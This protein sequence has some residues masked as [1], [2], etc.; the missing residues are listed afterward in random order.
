MVSKIS[1]N[2][3]YTEAIQKLLAV[4]QMTLK[5]TPFI[6]QGDEMGLVNYP[7]ASVDEVT[8][9]EAKGLVQELREKGVSEE[10]ILK[11]IFAGTREHTRILLPWNTYPDDFREEMRQPINET[12]TQAYKE[13]IALRK[14]D[15]AL[16]YGDFK[17]ISDAKDRFVYSRTFNGT[18]YIVDCNLGS[19]I[20][21]AYIPGTGYKAVYLSKGE[22]S[23][24]L[25]A[26]EARI[27]K[28][29]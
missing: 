3:E 20:K 11:T 7:F 23:H 1:M 5:G 26:Y 15:K 13:L 18:T 21:N 28:K 2:K 24:K 19:S 8:D 17:V 25:S 10:E 14:S 9:V 22:I 16:I 4:M 27:W 12:I 6:F 29:V